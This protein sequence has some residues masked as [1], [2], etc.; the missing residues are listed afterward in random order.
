MPTATPSISEMIANNAGISEIAAVL[1]AMDAGN[2]WAQFET[3]G[4][5]DMRALYDLAAESRPLTLAD[6]VPPEVD[7]LVPVVHRGRNTLPMPNSQ[8]F[9]SKVMCRP[10]DRTD[11]LYGYNDS[12]SGW[13]VGPGYY[14]AIPTVGND[15]WEARGGVVVDYYQVPR[16]E[17]PANWPSVRANWVGLQIFVYDHT[18]DYMR[19]VSKHV[20]MGAAYK[21]EMKLDH[22]FVLVRQD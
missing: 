1:D 8:R 22:Y 12:P 4:R 9:F 5:A 19:R 10:R 2:R 15:A 16:G 18:R 14:V 7:S 21:F 13:Y 17:V 6:F 3:M 20:T 11:E